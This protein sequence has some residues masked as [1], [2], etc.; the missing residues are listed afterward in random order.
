LPARP[1][2]VCL[3]WQRLTVDRVTSGIPSRLH[4]RGCSLTCTHH[5]L[6]TDGGVRPSANARIPERP[7][8]PLE[9]LSPPDPPHAPHAT[10]GLRRSVP[11]PLALRVGWL[12][13]VVCSSVAY[14]LSIFGSTGGLLV[15]KVVCFHWKIQLRLG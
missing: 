12:F 4:D 2:R 10:T 6:R 3:D 13:S 14:T 9:R 15:G 8:A 5:A 7:S 11:P 1:S